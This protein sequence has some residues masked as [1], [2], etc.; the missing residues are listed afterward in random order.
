MLLEEDIKELEQ[1]MVSKYVYIKEQTTL[2]HW[3]SKESVLHSIVVG[4]T[5]MVNRPILT[6]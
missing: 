6:K 3:W 1:K 5:Q 2:T 4:M